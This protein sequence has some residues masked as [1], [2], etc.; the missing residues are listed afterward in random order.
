MTKYFL[1]CENI[2]QK[3]LAKLQKSDHNQKYI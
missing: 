3:Y 1:I 2:I